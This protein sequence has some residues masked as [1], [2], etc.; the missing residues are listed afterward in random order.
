MMNTDLILYYKE[1]AKEYEQVYLKPERQ[2]DIQ[3][4]TTL[5]LEQFFEKTVLEIACGTGFWTERIAQTATSVLAMDINETVLEVAK[6]KK[7]TNA[8]VT[9][10]RADIFNYCSAHKYEALFGAFIW[11]HIPLQN[12]DK[13]LR[14]LNSFIS[15]D[16][17]IVLMDN[18]FVAGSN[19]PITYV[20]EGENTFQTRRLEDGTMHLIMKNFP[21][22]NFLREK[23]AELAINIQFIK[24]KYFW[25]LSYKPLHNE[26]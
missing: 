14:I 7:Y 8:P 20:D 10:E 13:F 4:T 21:T 16:G 3:S 23:L 12:I 9:F 26:S 6:Q 2:E 22:E 5:L 15:S 1:R 24:L 11:S 25:I 19:S 18:N 17:T